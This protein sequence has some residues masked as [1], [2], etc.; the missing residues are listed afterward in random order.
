MCSSQAYNFL[1]KM[2]KSKLKL[3]LLCTF[4]CLLPN[5]I[6]SK[7]I[8]DVET[9]VLSGIEFAKCHQG[10]MEAFPS[11]PLNMNPCPALK[12]L[13]NSCSEV[14]KVRK[15]LCNTSFVKK[16]IVF[17]LQKS[18]RLTIILIPLFLYSIF[19]KIHFISALS[20]NVMVSQFNPLKLVQTSIFCHKSCM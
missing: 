16:Y 13:V 5:L 14:V 17:F 3:L 2:F 18:N 7:I 6:D 15:E 9:Y 19:K 4:S 1:H 8:C 10:T 20:H 12:H 11:T